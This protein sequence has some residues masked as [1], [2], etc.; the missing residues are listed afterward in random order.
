MRKIILFVLFLI[1]IPSAFAGAVFWGNDQKYGNETFERGDIALEL[2]WSSISGCT[3]NSGMLRCTGLNS[4]AVYINQMPSPDTNGNWTAEWKG[5]ISG[6]S[7]NGYYYA[8]FSVANNSGNSMA[9]H[10]CSSS[11]LCIRDNTNGQTSSTFPNWKPDGTFQ[12]IKAVFGNQELAIY[13]NGSTGWLWQASKT[14][15]GGQM[16]FF[17]FESHENCLSFSDN[18]TFYNKSVYTPPILDTTPP[19]ITYYNLSNGAGCENW[20]TDK[21]NACVTS[22]VTPTI[23]F[24]TSENAWCRISANSTLTTGMNYSDMG[25]AR[26]CTGAAAGE[27]GKRHLCTL[28]LA[29]QFAYDFGYIHISCRDSDTNQNLT[30]TSDALRVNISGLEA[31]SRDSVEIGIAN[32][33]GTSYS[34]YTDQKIYARNSANSQSVGAF[35]KVVKKLNKVWAINYIGASD[36]HVNMFNITPV[37]YTLEFAN[38]TQTYIQNQTAFFINS[39]K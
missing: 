33:L 2:N 32:A 30:S 22:S 17:M 34:T 28:S 10:L 15:T 29:D 9:I 26:N 18:I 27:G 24:N 35:D 1:L 8:Y 23:Q 25:S 5:K 36:S 16:Q 12:N 11:T 6:C 13:V 21:T 4:K 7:A 39:T 37:L 20:N 19:S 31:T 3:D 38:K 14:W